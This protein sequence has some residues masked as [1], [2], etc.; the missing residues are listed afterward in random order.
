[1]N[2]PEYT[3]QQLELI[4]SGFKNIPARP[5]GVSAEI[6]IVSEGCQFIQRQVEADWIFQRIHSFQDFPPVERMRHQL[7]QLS[8][9]KDDEWVLFLVDEDDHIVVGEGLKGVHFPMSIFHVIVEDRIFMLPG[10]YNSYNANRHA[11]G[12]TD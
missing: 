10:E 6:F 7:W 9:T 3:A 4:I 11:Q 1:M 2:K 5:E 8:W 12:S